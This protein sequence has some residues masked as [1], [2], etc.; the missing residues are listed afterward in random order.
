MLMEL[1][2]TDLVRNRKPKKATVGIKKYLEAYFLA[3]NAFVPSAKDRS[4][5][6][7]I[8]MNR[9]LS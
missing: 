1:L 2:L 6:N 3:N 7:S 4:L 9:E 8:G 5:F